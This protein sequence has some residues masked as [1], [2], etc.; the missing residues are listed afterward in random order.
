MLLEGCDAA[1]LTY[2]SL[3]VVIACCS[4]CSDF[5]VLA[6][7]LAIFIEAWLVVVERTVTSEPKNVASCSPLHGTSLRV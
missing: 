4:I 1:G 6:A 5:F 3:A 7:H 2:A